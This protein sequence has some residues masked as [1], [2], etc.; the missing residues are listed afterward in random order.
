MDIVRLQKSDFAIA[1]D[2]LAAA[3]AQDPLISHSLPEAPDA[4]RTALEKMSEGALN[5]GHPY[6]RIYT[7]AGE[8]KGVAIWQPP[9]A[10][11]KPLAELWN[12]L[13]S[14]LLQTPFYLRWDRIPDLVWMMSIFSTLHETLMP[15]P[16]WYLMMLGVSPEC[17]GQGIGG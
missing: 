13:T 6:E 11:E 8:P 14:G 16:H 10:S 4:K 17:Q 5:F 15:E 1:V 3:F 2:C 12:L 7:T 9:G